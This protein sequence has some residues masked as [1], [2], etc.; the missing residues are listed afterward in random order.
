[1]RRSHDREGTW[2]W[3]FFRRAW[4]D[5]FDFQNITST[6]VR[7]RGRYIYLKNV[8]NVWKQANIIER[9]LYSWGIF[10]KDGNKVQL[11]NFV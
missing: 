11:G 9:T 4:A 3:E 5:H 2:K 8:D 1:M 7:F 6:L 10:I